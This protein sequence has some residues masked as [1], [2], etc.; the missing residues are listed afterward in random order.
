[1]MNEKINAMNPPTIVMTIFSVRNCPVKV[2]L[3]APNDFRIPI[4]DKRSLIRVVFMLIKFKEGM[5][6]KM[7]IIDESI[8]LNESLRGV[9]W[10][11]FSRTVTTWQLIKFLPSTGNSI[12]FNAA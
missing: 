10:I 2:I 4:S 1:M 12:F 5:N 3:V 9:S 7:K 8:M 6:S 11:R